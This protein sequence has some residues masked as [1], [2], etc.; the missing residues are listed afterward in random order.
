MILIRVFKNNQL[1]EVKQLTQSSVLIGSGDEAQLRLK[2]DSVS[3]LHALIELRSSGYFISDLGSKTGIRIKSQ[4]VLDQSISAGEVIQIG[5]FEL[6]FF[7]GAPK[8]LTFE[9]T[10]PNIAA[11]PEKKNTHS[12]QNPTAN[13]TQIIVEKPN[14]QKSALK[15]TAKEAHLNFKVPTNMKPK[16][17]KK[18]QTFSPANQISDLK[19][20]FKSTQGPTLEVIVTWRER[21]LSTQ[22]FWGKKSITLGSLS[23]SQ[24]Q[25]PSHFVPTQIGFIDLGPKTS[26][27]IP[28]YM[29]CELKR[30]G[31]VTLQTGTS[32]SIQQGDLLILTLGAPGENEL[33][34]FLRFI[35]QPPMAALLGTDLTAGEMTGVIGSLVLV[36]LFG[37]YISLTSPSLT[38]PK[39]EQEPVRRAQF[40]YQEKLVREKMEMTTEQ[41]EKPAAAKTSSEA[42]KQEKQ[43]ETLRDQKAARA[44]KV[45]PKPGL[46]RP[47]KFTS[48]KSG[49]AV[50]MTEKQSAS[51]QSKDVTKTGIL[52][53]LGG[54]GMRQQLDQAYSGTG[55]LLGTANQA[56]GTSG[57]NENRS[58][59]DLGSKI[60]DSGAGGKGVSMTGIAGV[61][62]K[63]RSSGQ[64]AYG[65]I[66]VGGKGSVAINI[67]GTGAGFTGGLDKEGIRRVIKSIIGQIRACYESALRSQEN[68]EGSFLVEFDINDQGKVLRSISKASTIGS[69]AVENCVAH[70]IRAQKFPASPKGVVGEVSYPFTFRP[71]N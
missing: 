42:A 70:R 39:D 3:G 30:N 68:L 59:D 36:A 25:V 15:V 50:K 49:G 55:E 26:V 9:N 46:Q 52:G 51:A 56:T 33:Q 24:I 65:D 61:G 67:E 40:V 35:P 71:Q 58:G 44:S 6:H 29:Q 21:I 64:S 13:T 22:H 43:K 28:S 7:V 2:D 20:Y 47:K 8:S 17:K 1:L 14:P 60:K 38:G 34:I 41:N 11:T 62:T 10:N 48:V 57:Q 54:G 66:G 37:V 45:R 53:S 63:G 31:Q 4:S 32:A 69:K 27:F 19:N 18:R 5:N 23:H 12:S 16:G